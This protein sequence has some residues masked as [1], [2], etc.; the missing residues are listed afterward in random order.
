MTSK[1]TGNVIKLDDYQFAGDPALA[2]G[3]I[4]ARINA[5]DTL[6]GAKPG[7]IIV[8]NGNATITTQI[9]IQNPDRVI[10]FGLGTYTMNISAV[11]AANALLVKADRVTV[12]GK[13]KTATILKQGV[14]GQDD[15]IRVFKTSYPAGSTI[16][17]NVVVENMTIDGNQAN[18]THPA[19]DT[20]GNGVNGNFC[21]NSEFRHLIVKN[22]VYQGALFQGSGDATARG[23]SIHHCEITACGEFGAGIEGG[24]FDS[25]IHSNYVHDLITVPQVAGG[26][27]AIYLSQI[28]GQ[29]ESGTGNSVYGNTVYNIPATGIIVKDGSDH[30]NI[31]GNIIKNTGTTAGHGIQVASSALAPNHVKIADNVVSGHADGTRAAIVVQNSSGA[32]GK[33]SITGNKITNCNGGGIQVNDGTTSNIEGNQIINVGTGGGAT[34]T[35]GIRLSGNTARATVR[36]NY[37]TGAVGNGI[38]VAAGTTDAAIGGNTVFS[39]TAGNY[40]DAGTRTVFDS[41]TL[42]KS[43]VAVSAPADATEDTLAT[44]TIPANA[45]GANGAIRFRAMLS[46]TNS[47]N[48]KTI[49]VKFGGT[50]IY[51]TVQTASVA[52]ELNG[53]VAN[54]NATNSQT[55]NVI[56]TKQ[57]AAGSF[58]AGP[59]PAAIDTTAA[60]TLTITGQKATAGETLTLES[61]VCDLTPG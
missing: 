51:A 18:I 30:A 49:R 25:S 3:D 17:N 35:D 14:L 56:D 32:T 20:Y 31:F 54:R 52:L 33:H 40:S 16:V 58:M 61:Y 6:L 8:P 9:A 24:A 5:A 39:N 2:G 55:S 41:Y 28:V 29:T 36:G 27:T 26:G 12:R 46:Y 47:V 13:S 38:A 53:F 23:N 21:A 48:N 19:T 10:E 4:G 7:T 45:L 37:V 44:I 34:S 22:C 42:A 50:Q 11:A 59:A 1:A 60:T 15:V 57:A 43:A